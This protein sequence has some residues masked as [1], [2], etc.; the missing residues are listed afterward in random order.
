MTVV[1]SITALVDIL[2]SNLFISWDTGKTGLAATCMTCS[3]CITTIKRYR[4]EFANSYTGG[5]SY[6]FC[7]VTESESTNYKL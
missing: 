3:G 4:D 1:T 2:A 5:T 7:S 6:T